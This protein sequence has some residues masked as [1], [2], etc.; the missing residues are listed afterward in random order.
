MTKRTLLW[1]VA[2]ILMAVG[3]LVG[4]AGGA[5]MAVFGTDS[6]ASTGTHRIST[7]TTALVAPIDDISDTNGIA[8]YVGRPVLRVSSNDVDQPIFLGVGR[9]AD[10]ERYLAA[11]SI[12]RVTDLDLTPY[13]L[14]TT[15]RGGAARVAPPTAQRFWV[16]RLTSATA[17]TLTWKIRDG[18]YRVVVMN[19]DG[20][21]GVSTSAKVSLKVPDLFAIGLGITV[22][23]VVLLLLGVWVAIAAARS[24]PRP[25]VT[26]QLPDVPG[27]RPP[28]AAGRDTAAGRSNVTQ[29]PGRQRE[30]RDPPP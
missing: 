27:P 20:S 5:L 2:V 28:S 6:T 16:A 1:I 12:D 9:A 15:R 17:A 26:V 4:V 23:G 3:L 29:V 22:G 14:S 30:D 19:A 11:A 13:R 25:V 21:A 24:R 7:P 18:S 10:V 8:H